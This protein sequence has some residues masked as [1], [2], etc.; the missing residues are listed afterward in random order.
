MA[1]TLL[2]ENDLPIFPEG[3]VLFKVVHFNRLGRTSE[4][5]PNSPSAHYSARPVR[6]I[7]RLGLTTNRLS[8]VSPSPDIVMANGMTKTAD[9]K[10]ILALSQGLNDTGG[11][12]YQLDPTTLQATP[13]LSSFNVTKFNSLNDIK[14][15][16]DGII[17]FSDPVYGFE[18]GF[19][20]GNAQLG[21]NVYRYD[22]H[23]QALTT[24]ITDLHRPNGIALSDDRRNGNGCTLFVTDTGIESAYG[25][26]S[27]YHG[28]RESNLY[29]MKDASVSSGGSC[30]EPR[31]GPYVLQPLVAA[32]SG[33]QD[34]IHVHESAQMLLYCDGDGL[35]V[36]SIPLVRPLG[37]IRIPCTQLQFQQGEGTSTVYI[38]AET[39]LYTLLLT[40]VLG[41][42]GEA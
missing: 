35:W 32:V 17:F 29:T 40:L 12:I 38:L 13:I 16:A 24:L 42:V 41:T 21:S 6:Q 25:A 19:R 20:T 33:V 34:G 23:T 15:T 4:L 14:V 3:P 37:L 18:Q 26:Q 1:S 28:F 27:E 39:R 36:W 7:Y 8:V 2:L 10:N 11:V 31:Q 5:D 22:T 9:G 30:F